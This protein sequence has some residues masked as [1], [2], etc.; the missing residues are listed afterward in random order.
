VI[1]RHQNKNKKLVWEMAA[2]IRRKFDKVIKYEV[3]STSSTYEMSLDVSI[4]SVLCMKQN[5]ITT[6]LITR[7]NSSLTDHIALCHLKDVSLLW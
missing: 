6:A 7:R 4:V 1:L 2:A 5:R 3:Y